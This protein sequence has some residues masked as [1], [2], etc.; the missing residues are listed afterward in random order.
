MSAQYPRTFT[1]DMYYSLIKHLDIHINE[2]TFEKCKVIYKELL[3]LLGK[4]A[5]YLDSTNLQYRLKD[6]LM[7]ASPAKFRA[8][9]TVD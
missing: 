7:I 5:S 4:P 9:Y 6:G 8:D 1:L 3:Y 2:P